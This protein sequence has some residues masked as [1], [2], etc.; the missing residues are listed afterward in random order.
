MGSRA[1][2]VIRGGA[3]R[4]IHDSPFMRA[5]HRDETR[6]TPTVTTDTDRTVTPNSELSK[7][8]NRESKAVAEARGAPVRSDSKRVGLRIGLGSLR[9]TRHQGA[10]KDQA[11]E[12]E[13]VVLDDQ[14]VTLRGRSNVHGDRA[15]HMAL[16]GVH[17]LDG[18][19]HLPNCAEVGRSWA[20]QTDRRHVMAKEMMSL[21]AHEQITVGGSVNDRLGDGAALG[22]VHPLVY[23]RVQACASK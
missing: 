6:E 8:A 11:Q 10:E 19:H 3:V 13:R 5:R 21:Q 2:C 1:C 23:A 7:R 4:K 9:P 17:Q 14:H 18:A 15:E 22:C 16:L 20:Q 12:L